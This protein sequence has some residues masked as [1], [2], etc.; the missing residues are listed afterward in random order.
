[1]MTPTANQWP[2]SMAPAQHEPLAEEARRRRHADHAERPDGESPHRPR[3][4]PA[5]AVEL[6]HLGLVRRGVDRARRRRTA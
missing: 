5:D 2:A 6:A 1:M 3:H 4:A